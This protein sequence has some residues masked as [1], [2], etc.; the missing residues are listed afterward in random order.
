MEL[1]SA[2]IKEI[3]ALREKKFREQTGLFTVE[4]EKVVAE[5]LS[6]GLEV[7]EVYRREEIGEKAME[8][9]S[10]LSSPSP[11][12]AVVRIPIIP[13]PEPKG[14]CLALDAVRDPGNLGT[15]IRL[16]DWFGIDTVYI[17]PDSVEPFNP[18]VVNSAM[19]SLFRKLPVTAD[20]PEL[21]KQFKAKGMDVFGTF[22]GGEN[23]YTSELPS[24]GLIVMGNEAHGIC[25]DVAKEVT[26]RLT[27]PSFGSAAES[28]NVSVATAVTI[29]EFKRRNY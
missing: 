6:S 4:G 21:C 24:E 1:S 3:R 22:L 18:K 16:A 10:A 5:A 26:R 15:I 12:L 7:V 14:L 13:L 25:G 20:I 17:S 28:L 27:I 8:R 23:V 19:G 2:R 11:V 9:I 29:S